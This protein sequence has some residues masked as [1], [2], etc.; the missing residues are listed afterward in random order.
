MELINE[1]K[2]IGLTTHESKTYFCLLECGPCTGYEVSKKSCLPKSNTYAALNNLVK[3]NFAYKSEGPT[4]IFKARD[5]KEISHNLVS[6]LKT[7]LKYISDNLP[8][9]ND[10]NNRFIS[11]TGNS[12]ILN[13]IDHMIDKAQKHISIDMW[14][15]EFDY[16][17]DRLLFAKDRGIKMTIIVIGHVSEEEKNMFQSIYEHYRDEE[18]LEDGFRDINI[19]SD[20]NYSLSATLGHNSC[21]G[22]FSGNKS[23]VTLAES[24]FRHDIYIEE[25]KNIYG[26]ELNEKLKLIE[27]KLKLY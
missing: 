18:W 7:G 3:K 12:K 25:L 10:S 4:T 23:F 13:K 22:V 9:T 27:E 21:Q 11:I 17:Q 19:I 8:K 15:E 1:L 24:A 26:N 2:K 16:F 20:G 14:R 5:F 6:D